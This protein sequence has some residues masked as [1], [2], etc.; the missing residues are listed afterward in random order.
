ML[1]LLTVSINKCI[2]FTRILHQEMNKYSS[3]LRTTHFCERLFD[4]DPHS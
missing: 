3:L 1:I 4:A 2:M